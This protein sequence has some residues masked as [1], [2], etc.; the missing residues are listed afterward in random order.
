MTLLPQIAGLQPSNRLKHLPLESNTWKISKTWIRKP[1]A[2]IDTLSGSGAL[3][4]LHPPVGSHMQAEWSTGFPGSVLHAPKHLGS[5]ISHAEQHKDKVLRS[6]KELLKWDLATIVRGHRLNNFLA[7]L[8]LFERLSIS[9][10]SPPSFY[11]TQ[12]GET[13]GKGK[14][15]VKGMLACPSECP[16]A[17]LF[18]PLL[19]A[20]LS[21][22]NLNS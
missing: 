19:I 22:P 1:K 12:C 6:R 16:L 4:Q 5:N 9:P 20:N 7:K 3:L 13:R 2:T 18:L 11:F 15:N 17:S 10:F 21:W 14:R 8:V